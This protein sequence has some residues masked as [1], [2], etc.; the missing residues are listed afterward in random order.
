VYAPRRIRFAEP[1]LGNLRWAPPVAWTNKDNNSSQVVDATQYGDACVQYIFGATDKYLGSEDCLFLNVYVSSTASPN[2]EVPV[3]VFVHGGSY[4][5]GAGSLPLYWGTDAVDFWKGAG[6]IVTVNYRLNAFGFLGAEELR[7]QDKS[8][9]STGNYGIQDQRLAFEWVRKNIAAFGGD[10]SRVTV[11]G[12]SAGAGS[13]TVHLTA[14]RSWPSFDRAILES[15]AFAAWT[16]IPMSKAQS[17]FDK[18]QQDLGC[19]D[20]LCM[21]QK[22]TKE[23]MD[24]ARSHRGEAVATHFEIAWAPVVD[25]VEMTTHPWIAL[26][27]GSVADVPVIQGSNQ[28]E[29]ALFTPVP[30]SASLEY[31]KSYWLLSGYSAREVSALTELYIDG[32]TYPSDP[33]RAS[34]NWWAAER[35]NGDALFSCPTKYAS[36]HFAKLKRAGSRKSQSFMYHWEHSPRNQNLT[37]HVSEIPYVFHLEE[38]LPAAEELQMADIMA[39][40]WGN[41]IA[42]GDPNIHAMGVLP[43]PPWD[44]YTLQADNSITLI[45]F[46]KIY[47]TNAMKKAEC[48]LIITHYH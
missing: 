2:S 7:S 18:L 33:E 43:L 17:S 31:V 26:A 30:K 12:E 27:D 24:A 20:I 47:M 34:V 36:Q 42:N 48:D 14:S 6:I 37:R 39:S 38:T 10:S 8:T 13:L 19:A 22:S 40:Y 46:D 5:T 35:Q 28:D 9:G 23:I 1:P 16:V 25:G 45:D 29:G 32:K 3:G 15:G 21:L 4:L 11:F 41:F 44:A